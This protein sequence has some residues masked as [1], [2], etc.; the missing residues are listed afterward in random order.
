MVNGI[1]GKK[2]AMT[3]IFLETGEVV[4]ATV[5]EAGPCVILQVKSK[6]TDGYN[7]VQL[8]FDTV[9]QSRVK[10]P[11]LGKFKKLNVDPKRF[12]KEIRVSGSEGLETS[13][14]ITVEI[15]E[16][17][18]YVD[19][20][21]TSIGKGVQG[22]VKRWHWHGGPESHGSMSHRAPGSIGASSDPSRVYKGQHL[23]GQMGNKR[24]TTQNLE[25]AEVDIENNLLIIKGSVPGH[26][27]GYVLIKKALKKKKKQPKVQV[28][29]KPK[30]EGIKP[31]KNKK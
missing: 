1:L 12:I 20:S 2:I 13:Q 6:E 18:D 19:I 26:R 15:F 3:Q 7:A 8:A 16:K 29:A 31:A 25:V 23:P 24:V 27:D 10:K 17:G 9:K 11:L 21:G 30:K 28:E 4:P 5:I 14:M 22:G